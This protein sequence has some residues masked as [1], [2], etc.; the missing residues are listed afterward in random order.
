MARRSAFFRSIAVVAA[1]FVAASCDQRPGE[2]PLAPPSSEAVP[3]SGLVGDL[4]S[5]V[6]DLLRPPPPGPFTLITEEPRVGDLDLTKL[7]T[8]SGGVVSVAGITVD[9][10]AGAVT[11][12]T[13]FTVVALPT[14]VIDADLTALVPQLFGRVLNIGELGFRK[15]VT[16]TM[17]YARAT[18]VVDPSKLVIVY[19]N[20]EQNKLEAL[21]ST[22][23]T[24]R[25]TVSAQTDHFSKYGMASN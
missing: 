22:V 11:V 2:S 18:N 20:Y 12:P 3:Q 19:Y 15:P 25:K 14:A 16:I 23:D 24:V 4:L 8:V 13:L 7:I 1:L 5:P 21:P 9:V 6:T 17:S 10:P